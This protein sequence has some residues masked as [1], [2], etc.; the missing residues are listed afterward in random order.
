MTNYYCFP[1][2]HGCSEALQLALDYVY[3]QHPDGT[4]IIF[5]GDYIDRGPDDLGVLNIVMNP[6]SNYEFITLMGNHEQMFIESYDNKTQFYNT[7][8]AK[9]I[10]GIVSEIYPTYDIIHSNIDPNI[11]SWMKKL[12]L[13]H[14]ED[15]NVFAHAYYDPTLSSED[16]RKTVC[17]WDR[18]SD[19]EPYIN[20]KGLYLTHGHTP[21]KNGPIKTINRLNLDVGAVFYGRYVIAEYASNKLGPINFHEFE[22]KNH[23]HW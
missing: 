18:L 13:F 10:A 9:Q 6:P 2:I 23:L 17:L 14:F 5:L 3:K 15:Q 11:I 7:K 20:D 16:Q 1:D 4:K 8:S 19:T 22:F 12:K 21:R